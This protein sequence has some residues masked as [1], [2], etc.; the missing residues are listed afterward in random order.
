MN[1]AFIHTF[2]AA[3]IV[4]GVLAIKAPYAYAQHGAAPSATS[5]SAAPSSANQPASGDASKTVE[6]VF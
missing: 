5:S 2:F 1:R 6:Q 3:L 4:V